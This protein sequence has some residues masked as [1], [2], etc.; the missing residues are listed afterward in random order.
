MDGCLHTL[1]IQCL[2]GERSREHSV[3]RAYTAIHTDR[4]CFDIRIYTNR[5]TTDNMLKVALM[6]IQLKFSQVPVL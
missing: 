5:T 6:G 1:Y 3:H 4:S 2:Y